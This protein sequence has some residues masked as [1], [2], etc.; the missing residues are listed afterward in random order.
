MKAK[1][2][3][4]KAGRVFIETKPTRAARQGRLTKPEETTTRRGLAAGLGRFWAHML[5]Q[6]EQVR[7]EQERKGNGKK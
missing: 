5:E 3:A 7:K 4:E 2:E 1:E 6:A